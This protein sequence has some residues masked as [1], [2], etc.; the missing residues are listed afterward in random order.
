MTELFISWSGERSKAVALVLRD[1]L[2][3]VINAL[4]PWLSASDIEKGTR[5]AAEVTEKLS[6]STVGIICL[7]PENL[8]EDWILFE[9]GALSKLKNAY[10][11]T[12][13]L[14]LAS[15][16]VEFPLAQFQSTGA[17]KNE[18]FELMRTLNNRLGGES[19]PDA[20]L[21]EAF[22]VWWPRLEDKLADIS[23]RITATAGRRSDRDLIEEILKLVRTQVLYAGRRELLD[24]LLKAEPE[25]APKEKPFVQ[26]VLDAFYSIDPKAV[27]GTRAIDGS[28][29]MIAGVSGTGARFT[30]S[31]PFDTPRENISELLKLQLSGAPVL[32]HLHG[33]DL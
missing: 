12:F 27:V 21:A 24:D 6:L 1:W 3:K 18:A 9:A 15:T 26:V 30:V 14:G 13:L 7:T 5:W 20:H 17:T 10:V 16:E 19:L 31:I 29:V 22:E 28:G 8:H 25:I 4:K 33:L 23:R 32:R 2:P 11:C